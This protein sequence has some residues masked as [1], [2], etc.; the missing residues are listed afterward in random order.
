[1]KQDIRYRGR[2]KIIR[3]DG[4]YFHVSYRTDDPYPEQAGP[5][6]LRPNID[7]TNGMEVGDEGHLYYISTEAS[8]LYYLSKHN[9]L[10]HMMA[11]K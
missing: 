7:V 3:F 4:E 10:L 11:E 2:A 1:M 5:G 9:K 8:G 6:G